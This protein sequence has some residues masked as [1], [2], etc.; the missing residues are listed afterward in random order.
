MDVVIDEVV[1]RI[2]VADRSAVLDEAT[3]A[4]L[5]RAVMAGLDERD[6]RQRRR[7]ADTQITDDGRGGIAGRSADM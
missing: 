5:V 2:K 7:A 3:V 1:A 6:I 4:N